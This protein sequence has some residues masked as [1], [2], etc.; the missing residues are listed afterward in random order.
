[1]YFAYSALGDA[2]Y[3]TLSVE[4]ATSNIAVS[5]PNKK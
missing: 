3:G 2:V 1:M 4:M 5:S